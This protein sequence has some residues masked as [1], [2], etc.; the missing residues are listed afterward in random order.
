M[1]IAFER[2]GIN[3]SGRSRAQTPSHGLDGGPS[4]G[5]RNNPG[6]SLNGLDA[7]HGIVTTITGNHDRDHHFEMNKSWH[8]RRGSSQERLADD[9]LEPQKS[10]R[11]MVLVM[12]EVNVTYEP[13]RERLRGGDIEDEER[14]LQALPSPTKFR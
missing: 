9:M 1:R 14:G 7:R 8:T 5:N 4:R 12:D 2:W 10:P 13:T 11:D 6:L 3:S